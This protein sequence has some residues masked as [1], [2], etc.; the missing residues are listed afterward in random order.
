MQAVKPS[1][2]QESA[3]DAI[4]LE[5]ARAGPTPCETS[6]VAIG[7][8]IGRFE[9]TC[10]LGR[11]GFGIVYEAHDSLLRR[12]VAIKVTRD[13]RAGPFD[14]TTSVEHHEDAFR[15]EAETI[16][17]LSHPRIV[18]L[19]DFGR[20][21]GRPFL[22]LELLQGET[23]QQRLDRGALS[24]REA[25]QVGV[26]IAEGFAAAHGAGICHH[27]LKPSNVFLT[28]DGGLK[29]LDFGIATM[30]D[31]A[32]ADASVGPRAGTLGYAAPERVRGEAGDARSDLFSFGALLYAALT[33]RLPFPPEDDGGIASPPPR[34][35]D[36]LPSIA[37]ALDDLVATLLS[38]DP[39]ARLSNAGAVVDALVAIER[40]NEVAD[41]RSLVHTTGYARSG[42]VHIAYQVAGEGALDIL[43]VPPFVS[44][45]ECW[46]DEPEGAR[47]VGRL[48][49][50]GRL[51]LFDK[52][53]TGMS[54]RVSADSPPTMSQRIDDLR[55]VMDVSGSR[56]A[57]LFGI[58]EG[59]QLA[60]AFAARYPDKT[61]A[62]ALYG[63]AAGAMRP[64]QARALSERVAAGWGTGV[65][66]PA[67][68]P[69]ARGSERLRRWLARI[70]RLSA[71]PASAAALLE[72]LSRT[73]V[74]AEL[75]AVVA[76]TLVVHRTND[77]VVPCGGG[78][79][80]AR[81]I[82]GARFVEQEGVDHLP[83]LGDSGAVLDAVERF[84]A[85]VLSAR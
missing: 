49:K 24:T 7:E 25:L 9:I 13:E 71:T 42:E 34:L 12:S 53:G 35:A 60:V 84:L 58:S 63:G 81:N 78:R 50:M 54:D 69:S 32:R 44:H 51:I 17:R 82:R 75:S 85:E 18:T 40:E 38:H 39:S 65:L 3:L 20:H 55:A 14:V 48:A 10:E 15:R 23:L 47:F 27:D 33:G 6:T 21:Q 36:A 83:M 74:H 41:A 16:A 52:R 43:L 64:D 5:L 70:E 45:V 22:V 61:L 46:W 73:D 31:G 68:A 76:P 72:M 66:V 28:S 19:F 79:A 37:P 67:F 62:L 26:R 77:G 2:N 8:S 4:L 56:R 80:L 57:A 30:M 59:V 11:G 29:L 1:A